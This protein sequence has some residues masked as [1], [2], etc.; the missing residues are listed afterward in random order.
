MK[1]EIHHYHHISADGEVLKRLDSMNH[2]LDKIMNKQE[3]LDLALKNLDEGTNL[4]AKDLEDLRAE[5]KDTVSED[6]LNK[7]DTNI[8]VLQQLGKDNSAPPPPSA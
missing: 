3:R 5:V 2:K 6:S 1:I 8:S 4:I 7:L